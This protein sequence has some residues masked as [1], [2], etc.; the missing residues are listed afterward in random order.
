MND[1]ALH[2]AT[3][4]QLVVVTDRQF[5]LF[6]VAL[7]PHDCGGTIAVVGGVFAKRQAR[8]IA[9]TSAPTRVVGDIV[10]HER[11]LLAE[12]TTRPKDT[13]SWRRYAPIQRKW[14]PK[15]RRAKRDG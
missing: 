3:F 10:V 7:Y 6:A 5:R 12:P 11:R 15:K 1:P 9:P 14:A 4:G 2:I 13:S 8:F